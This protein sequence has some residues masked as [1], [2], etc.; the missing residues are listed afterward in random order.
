MTGAELEYRSATLAGVSYPRR[1][2]ELIV[3]PYE[4]PG[5]VTYHG[6]EIVE[7]CSRGAWDGVQRR[8][9][10]VRV[11]RDHRV[12][13]TVGKAI[14]FHPSREDG[15]VAQLR[16]ARTELGDETLTLADEGILDA[17]AEF[18]LLMD[19]ATGRARKDAEVWETR[20]RR[21]LNHLWLAGIGLTPDPVFEGANVLAVRSAE[22][23][24]AV[25]T[26]NRDRLEL[27]RLNEQYA[28]L[29][30]RYSL[31]Q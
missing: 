10:K 26:P 24:A 3:M 22:K 21:R 15:L 23:P 13:R 18:S 6:R 14:E 31:G 16:I 25:P 2:I 4:Q 9:G 8:A 28:A 17:S 5:I 30:R 11:N 20:S 27:E 29:D 1:T 12:D 7:I 19:E